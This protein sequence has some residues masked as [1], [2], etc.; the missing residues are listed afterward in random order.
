MS[1]WDERDRPVLTHLLMHPPHHGVLWVDT[2][3]DAPR[4]DFPALSDND[5][6]LAVE[7]LHDAGYVTWTYSEAEGGGTRQYQD[8]MVHGRR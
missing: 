1:V 8:F 4:P 7:T 3:R 6:H 2:R 5:F